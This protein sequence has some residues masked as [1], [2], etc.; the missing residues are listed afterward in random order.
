MTTPWQSKTKCYQK[1]TNKK[2]SERN[3]AEGHSDVNNGVKEKKKKSHRAIKCGR[4]TNR[5]YAH[6]LEM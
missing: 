2:K 1:Q 6:Y 5:E 3:E 4:V